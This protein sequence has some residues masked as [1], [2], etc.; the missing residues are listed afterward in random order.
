METPIAPIDKNQSFCFTCSP[1]RPCFNECCRELNQYLTPYDILKLKQHLDMTSEVFLETYTSES[2]G[3]ETGLPIIYLKPDYRDQMKCPF[4][5]ESGCTVYEAR[6]ASCRTYPLARAVSRSRK[7][8]ECTEHWAIIR[9]DH[10]KGFE[11]GR[12]QTVREWIT[13][14]KIDEYNKMNDQ[15]M[16]LIA[17]KNTT[18]QGPLDLT[19]KKIFHMALYD[20]DTFRKHVF[21]K[22]LFRESGFLPDKDTLAKA[23]TDDVA[24]LG[25]GMAWVKYKIFT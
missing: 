5:S 19:S 8:G 10:C 17:L 12:S 11:N 16:E 4:V 24:L 20:L 7:T 23:G 18:I 22:E 15:M 6:P 1:D 25:I 14:Q 9:E 2:V 21:E 3:P 13:D